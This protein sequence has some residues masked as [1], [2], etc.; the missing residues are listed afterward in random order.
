MSVQCALIGMSGIR[1]EAGLLADL[2]AC[3]EAGAPA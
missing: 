2:L 1:F 3:E